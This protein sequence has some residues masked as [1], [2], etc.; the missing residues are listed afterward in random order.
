MRNHITMAFQRPEHISYVSMDEWAFTPQKRWRW[1][2]QAAWWFLR[3]TKGVGNMVKDRTEY[4]T[5]TINAKNVADTIVRSM[6]ELHIAHMR[7]KQVFMGP[8]QIDELH[9]DPRFYDPLRFTAP[10]GFNRKVFGL[11]VTV[12]P[13]MDGVL[14][15]TH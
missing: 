1:L 9:A 15:V 2:H 6:K 3:K 13:W 14:V 5:V 10:V 12:V 8:S 11:P 7:P 4:R